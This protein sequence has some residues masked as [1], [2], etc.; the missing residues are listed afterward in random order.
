VG[1]C[2]LTC[3]CSGLAA[4]GLVRPPRALYSA[5][6]LRYKAGM[7]TQIKRSGRRSVARN[8]TNH[9]E[10]IVV[11]LP[12]DV[13]RASGTVFRIVS[14]KPVVHEYSVAD[15]LRFLEVQAE[16][17]LDGERMDGVNRDAESIHGAACLLGAK[18][19][20]EAWA[21]EHGMLRTKAGQL[22]A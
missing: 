13:W 14:R 9:S 4:I 21:R 17:E 19:I 6:F 22:A 20:V 16:V 3:G 8:Q 11:D 15:V 5:G 12:K 2:R 7:K 18:A 1:F 10:G